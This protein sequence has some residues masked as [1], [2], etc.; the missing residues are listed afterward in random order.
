MKVGKLMSRLVNDLN[1]ISEVAHHGPEDLLISIVLLVGSFYMMYTSNLELAIVMTILVPLM[2]FI[3]VR[4]NLKFRKA[5]RVMRERLA[6]INARVESNFS[7]IRVVKAFT[8]E[9]NESED[10]ALG[11]ARFLV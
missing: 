3:G 6:E 2:I 4:Q 11:N 5:F 8:A 7:G 9:E 1:D 10:F